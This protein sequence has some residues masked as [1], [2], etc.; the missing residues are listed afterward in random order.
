MASVSRATGVTFSY[1]IT[2]S[3]A[4]R[5]QREARDL[6]ATVRLQDANIRMDYVEGKN[7]IGQ[8]NGY[9]I[10]QGDKG[11]FY[12]VNPKDKQ[13]ILMTADGFG[14]GFGALMNNPMLKMTISNTSFRFRDLGA[15]E[16]ILGY[17][18]RKV[19]T[20]YTST[21]EMKMLLINNKTTTSDSSDQWIAKV[22]FDPGSLEA[23]AKS[24]ASGVKSSNPEL[25]A[26]LAKYTNEYGRTGMALRSV[27]WSTQ[28]DKKGKVTAD[29]L[30]MEVT[31]IKTGALDASLFKV[32]DGFEVLDMSKLMQGAGGMK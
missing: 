18:T 17:V 24:F 29:T 8:K 5:K 10:V 26:D 16:E 21:I 3:A 19:R 32:P 23:W 7:P 30:T 15:G 31:D 22:D 9:T 4:D 2:S 13:A 28:T 1:R 27:T 25:A 20:Y 11:L 12:I 6:L 14:S